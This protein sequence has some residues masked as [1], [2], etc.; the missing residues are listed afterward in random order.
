[1]IEL[2][3]KAID[4]L[5][6]GNTINKRLDEH[7]EL[8]QSIE[9]STSLFSEKPW[10][11]THMAIQDDY[12]MRVF[13]MVYGC[14][15]DEQNLRKRTITG[16]PV[17]SRPS[18]LGKCGLPEYEHSTP[19]IE[20]ENDSQQTH[21][22]E[23]STLGRLYREVVYPIAKLWERKDSLPDGETFIKNSF[24]AVD[25]K[26]KE[27]TK[28]AFT[29]FDATTVVSGPFE[30]TSHVKT[31]ASLLVVALQ[32]AL[33]FMDVNEV[34][35]IVHTTTEKLVA[36]LG[37]KRRSPGEIVRLEGH[38]PDS[39]LGLYQIALGRGEPS[40]CVLCGNP[41]CKE[42]P[43]LFEVDVNLSRTGEFAYHV[44]ECHMLDV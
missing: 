25:Y 15:P 20:G 43:T 35:Q 1:M 10:H 40:E 7:R 31:P 38:D 26:E 5:Q 37:C 28:P 39:Y 29:R 44:S 30:S 9:G 41:R 3:E 11:I 22:Q 18:I 8:V 6:F 27:T 16:Q 17:R 12:L 2:S 24:H 23:R 14:W 34:E 4:L 36:S 19:V 21:D 42:W 33:F 32:H 13:H